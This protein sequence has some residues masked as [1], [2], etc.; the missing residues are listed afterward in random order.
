MDT[1]VETAAARF[2]HPDA[3]TVPAN[4]PIKDPT[5]KSR[6]RITIS[7]SS[8]IPSLLVSNELGGASRTTNF[9]ERE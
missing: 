6:L 8:F 3:L 9:D 7:S 2:I 5:M 1:G 4:D